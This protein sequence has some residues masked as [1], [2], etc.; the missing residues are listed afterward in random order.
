MMK[1]NYIAV[2][3]EENKKYYAYCLICGTNEN[4]LA[5][6]SIKGIL[7]ANICETKKAAQTLIEQWNNQYKA[8]GTYMFDAP[9]F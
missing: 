5:K 7:H 6:L 4:L 1:K 9:Q 3:I 2:T 8:N